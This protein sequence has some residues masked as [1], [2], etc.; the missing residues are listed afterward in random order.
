MLV[1]EQASFLKELVDL[2]EDDSSFGLL[3]PVLHVE[4]LL[5]GGGG[6]CF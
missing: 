5:S 4:K 3:F 2:H 6:T 1:A